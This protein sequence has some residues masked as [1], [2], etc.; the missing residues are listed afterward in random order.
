[1]R[2][3]DCPPVESIIDPDT[4]QG[5]QSTLKRNRLT[6]RVASAPDAFLLR[7]GFAVCGSCGHPLAA[8]KGPRFNYY[9]CQVGARFPERC[10]EMVYVRADE[11]DAAVWDGYGKDWPG[12]PRLIEAAAEVTDLTPL[13]KRKPDAAA[14]ELR[15]LVG[16][17]ASL[18]RAIARTDDPAVTD[19]LLSDLSVKLARERTLRTQQPPAPPSAPDPALLRARL[20]AATTYGRKR[21][22]LEVLRVK[23]RVQRHPSG[24]RG[25]L[26]VW[27]IESMLTPHLPDQ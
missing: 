12:V 9:R 26:P 15:G 25:R 8:Q 3:P 11:L 19:A 16:E 22:L 23:A 14:R 2:A 4:W 5:A 27:E 1:M 7:G 20:E 10:S 24:I 6:R 21:Q 13:P 18:R 17:I